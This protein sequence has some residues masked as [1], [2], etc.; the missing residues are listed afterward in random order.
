MCV[1]VCVCVCLCVCLC[2]GVCISVLA[3]ERRSACK[4]EYVCVSKRIRTYNIVRN[5][6]TKVSFSKKVK[7][8]TRRK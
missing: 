5:I 4:Y 2:L 3:Y 8:K 7:N 1:C 6:G